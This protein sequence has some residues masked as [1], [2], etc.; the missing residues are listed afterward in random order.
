M[1]NATNLLKRADGAR[2]HWQVT[3]GTP[4]REP[5]L[6]H[7]GSTDAR[8]AGK[9]PSRLIATYRRGAV[10]TSVKRT[11]TATDNTTVEAG[12]AGPSRPTLPRPH[13]GRTPRCWSAAAEERRNRSHRRCDVDDGA[14]H[15]TPMARASGKVRATS[16]T[17]AGHAA[18]LPDFSERVEPPPPPERDRFAK[19]Y[20]R[21]PAARPLG[22]KCDQLPVS[23]ANATTTTATN[24]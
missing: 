8:E 6:S 7:P 4:W 16:R 20:R 10:M 2:R 11:P 17:S 12:T 21:P 23:A 5:L 15:V 14:T 3:R 19:R 9:R 18:R 22:S 13:G 1:K 24:R